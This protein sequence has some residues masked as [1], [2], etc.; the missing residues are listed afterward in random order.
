MN[1]WKSCAIS[2]YI[3]IYIILIG[4]RKNAKIY[5]QIMDMEYSK[6]C[7]LF[8]LNQYCFVVSFYETF[9]S[10]QDYKSL[11]LIYIHSR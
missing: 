6:R 9:F 2:E 7:L 3:L 11:I 10:I 4:K 1:V 8:L 5:M